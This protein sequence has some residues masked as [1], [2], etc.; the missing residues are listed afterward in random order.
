M[1]GS[2]ENGQ[3]VPLDTAHRRT[4]LQQHHSNLVVY[5]GDIDVA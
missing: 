1:P 4:G 3:Q 2:P 5:R